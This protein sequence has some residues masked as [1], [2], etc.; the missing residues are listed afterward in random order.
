MLIDIRGRN[1]FMSYLI[2]EP[3]HY[4]SSKKVQ[5]RAKNIHNI[6]NFVMRLCTGEQQWTKC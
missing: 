1:L 2:V 3:T 6:I 5:Y 4:N